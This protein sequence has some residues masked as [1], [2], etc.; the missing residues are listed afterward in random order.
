M[1]RVV[2]RAPE[3]DRKIVEIPTS[4]GDLDKTPNG[5][6]YRTT[7]TV[8]TYPNNVALPLDLSGTLARMSQDGT[9]LVADYAGLYLVTFNI[10]WATAP[11]GPYFGYGPPSNTL[12]TTAV[13]VNGVVQG[14]ATNGSSPASSDF[15]T[16]IIRL[17]AGDTV[18]VYGY[19]NDPAPNTGFITSG[20]LQAVMLAP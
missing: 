13:Y 6:V 11:P 20:A 7:D 4:V 18:R 16:A 8:I 12:R 10:D 1:R 14:Y 2:L 19:N 9:G 17:A 3:T 15:G 5:K